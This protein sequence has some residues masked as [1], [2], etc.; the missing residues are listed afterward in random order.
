LIENSSAIR[1]ANEDGTKV[2]YVGKGKWGGIVLYGQNEAILQKTVDLQVVDGRAYVVLCG[3]YGENFTEE[4]VIEELKKIYT[5]MDWTDPSWTAYALSDDTDL[6]FRAEYGEWKVFVDLS[7]V[8]A[9]VI[10]FAH[11]I[12]PTTNLEPNGIKTGASVTIN[13]ITYTLGINQAEFD[14]GSKLVTVEVSSAE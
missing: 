11:H 14:W 3:T 12:T 5:Q 2:F 8:P 9:G 13:G 4:Q 10:V 7:S 1:V 6:I